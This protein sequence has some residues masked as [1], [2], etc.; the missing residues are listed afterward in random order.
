MDL[1]LHDDPIMCLF[2]FVKLKS[3][4]NESH[5]GNRVL[6]IIITPQAVSSDTV[7]LEGE[8]RERGRA[9]HLVTLCI[10]TCIY[11]TPNAAVL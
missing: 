8:Q 2:S 1:F 9:C 7:S 10:M 6:A 3:P 11:E 5:I 4:L